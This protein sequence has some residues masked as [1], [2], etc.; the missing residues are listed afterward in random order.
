[1]A[2]SGFG[3]ILLTLGVYLLI[4]VFRWERNIAFI[5][6]EIKAG[7]LTGKL[8]L[9]TSIIAVVILIA[10]IFLAYN[11]TDFSRSEVGFIPVLSFVSNMVWGVVIAGLIAVF[12]RVIDIYVRDKKT[13]W[14]YWVA[15]FSLFA[16]GF[17]SYAVFGSLYQALINWPPSFSI[18]PFFTPTFI[19]Y[20]SV[21]IMIAAV[22]AITYHYIKEIY[23]L[24]SKKL[25]IEE[26][27]KKLIEKS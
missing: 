11:N 8:S 12:G 9:Y 5:W 20:T 22:G 10:S 23:V 21:G 1:M 2:A 26:Q 13:P 19:V 17:I 3:A 4:R 27:T 6:Q 18:K 16:F 24:E 15:P 7:F 25:E 14:T